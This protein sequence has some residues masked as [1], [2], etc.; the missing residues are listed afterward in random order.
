MIWKKMYFTFE[1]S[2]LLS[3]T[4]VLKWKWK[5]WTYEKEHEEHILEHELLYNKC[6]VW[7]SLQFELSHLPVVEIDRFI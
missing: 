2:E 7:K 4:C 1:N 3:K 6:T 5:S